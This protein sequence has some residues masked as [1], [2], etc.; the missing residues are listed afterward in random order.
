MI[1]SFLPEYGL[2]K[3]LIHDFIPGYD[4]LTEPV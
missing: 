1:V 2:F 3:Y 4:F